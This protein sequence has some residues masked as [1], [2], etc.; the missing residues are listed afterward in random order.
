VNAAKKQLGE[1]RDMLTPAEQAEVE[2]ILTLLMNAVRTG[3]ISQHFSDW[4]VTKLA[5][6]KANAW[7]DRQGGRVERGNQ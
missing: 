5:E 2:G 7:H 4:L 1:W 6:E 3:Q